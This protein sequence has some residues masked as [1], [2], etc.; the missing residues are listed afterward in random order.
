[1]Q[2]TSRTREKSQ[3]TKS[4][5]KKSN[6]KKPLEYDPRSE[7]VRVCHFPIAFGLSEVTC[8][9]LRQ[10]GD[11][12]PVIQLGENSAGARRPDIEAWLARRAKK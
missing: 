6:N 12:P 7:V 10:K 4:D 3:R 5:D 2:R 8:W 11:F 9:R 1:M